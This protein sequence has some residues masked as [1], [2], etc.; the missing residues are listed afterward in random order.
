MESQSQAFWEMTIDS[1]EEQINSNFVAEI[2][3]LQLEDF[4]KS[5]NI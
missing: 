1:K 4:K 2:Y 5:T 3:Q